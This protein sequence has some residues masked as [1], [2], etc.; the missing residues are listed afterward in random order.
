[1]RLSTSTLAIAALLMGCPPIQAAGAQFQGPL[2]S[3]DVTSF[4]FLR[5]DMRPAPAASF[6]PDAW[7]FEAVLG[8][9][10]TWALSQNV[11]RYLKSVEPAGRRDLS[12]RY[13]D[14][15]AL[16]G[17]KYLVDLE[18]ANLDLVFRYRLS[19]RWTGYAIA[20]A[21][22]YQ[23]GFLDGF[24]EGFHSTFGLGTAGRLAAN[25]DQANE[26]YGLKSVQRAGFNAPADGGVT[27]PT[28]GVRYTRTVP[29]KQWAYSI[30]GAVKVAIAGERAMLSTGRTDIG[31]QGSLQRF[32]NR[33]ALYVDLA[34]VY[35]AGAAG[36]VAQDAQFIPTLVL[37][38]ERVF[39]AR[40]SLLLQG[41]VSSS[42]YSRGQTDLDEL[43]GT[44]YLLT[45]GVRHRLDRVQ[46]SFG[47]TEN[48]QNFNNTPDISVQFGVAWAPR[49][50]TRVQ[51]GLQD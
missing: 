38:Y 46:L 25:K 11:E 41:Y 14:I 44:K 35:Y 13:A 36:P 20:S 31:I 15:M 7:A 39:G 5:L 42:V 3:R 22:S 33:D 18:S 32:W 26:I 47:I 50:R 16:P 23:G 40:T 28:F 1:L 6:Q 8:Y 17:E 43:L 29:G 37:G 9:Q 34:A 45:L 4:G 27:D 48:L 12:T 2:R 21:V 10:N 30:E 51:V 19:E 49:A 24:I